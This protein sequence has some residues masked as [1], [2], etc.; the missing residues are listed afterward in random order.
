MMTQEVQ[1]IGVRRPVEYHPPI[2]PID[3]PVQGGQ[4]VSLKVR[5]RHGGSP[6]VAV[7]RPIPLPRSASR[8]AFFAAYSRA[9]LSRV[10]ARSRSMLA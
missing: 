6:G 1:E 8:L 4:G 7:Y 10:A 3:M 5:Q 2:M 9:A